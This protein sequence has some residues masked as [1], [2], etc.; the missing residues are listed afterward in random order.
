[1]H[2]FFV[3]VCSSLSEDS[4]NKIQ[5]LS[6]INSQNMSTASMFNRLMRNKNDNPFE[7]ADIKDYLRSEE[8][9]IT[10]LITSVS[11]SFW[12]N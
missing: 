2:E 6:S 9:E 8:Y 12:V 11:L 4:S 3:F 1:M 10:K 5:S 7:A